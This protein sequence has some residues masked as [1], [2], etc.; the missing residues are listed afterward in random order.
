M[1]LTNYR[2]SLI[3]LTKFKFVEN[4]FTV[5]ESTI[6]LILTINLSIQKTF[7][8][9]FIQAFVDDNAARDPNQK[10]I[11]IFALYAIDKCVR[12]YHNKKTFL[13]QTLSRQFGL[14]R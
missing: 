8:E 9:E 1:N 10:R 5:V 7:Y 3:I 12:S 2:P 6:Y 13:F 4:N 14:R 11:K